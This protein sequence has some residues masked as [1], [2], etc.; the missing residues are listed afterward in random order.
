MFGVICLVL[1]YD[2][3]ISIDEYAERGKKNDFPEIE[4]CPCCKGRTRLSRHGFYWRNAITDEKQH[5][6]PICR[7]KC[8]SCKKTVSLLPS[9]LLP[10]FQ[11]TVDVILEKLRNSLIYRKITGYHQLVL[12]YRKRFIRNLNRIEMFFRDTGFRGVLPKTPKE[13]AIRLLEMVQALGKATFLRR[14]NEHFTSNFMA[15]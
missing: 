4:Q 15:N 3:G 14:W 10:Y 13:K 9:F 5:R 8:P 12:F 6:L 1:P 11:H 2:F 7:L